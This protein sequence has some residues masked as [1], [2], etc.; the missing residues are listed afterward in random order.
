MASTP[1][2]LPC[3]SASSTHDNCCQLTSSLKSQRVSWIPQADVVLI[4]FTWAKLKANTQTEVY[5][6][7]SPH[8]HPQ[9]RRSIDSSLASIA[10][11]SFSS[12]NT[13]K[14]RQAV[15]PH[16]ALSATKPNT[17]LC[18]VSLSSA[19]FEFGFL[20]TC[21]PSD[22]FSAVISFRGFEWHLLGKFSFSYHL[23]ALDELFVSIR[24]KYVSFQLTELI[25]VTTKD[26]I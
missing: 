20:P 23:K 11:A 25:L 17:A 24:E 6:D 2:A 19:H 9:P 5:R 8:H 14:P 4:V 15:T 1:S 26:P 13:S 3:R 12:N 21:A 18:C 10:L 16:S 22:L 7:T